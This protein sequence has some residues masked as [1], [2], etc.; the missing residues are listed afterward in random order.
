MARLSLNRLVKWFAVAGAIVAAAVVSAPSATA[1]A[2][3]PDAAPV[4]AARDAFRPDGDAPITSSKASAN[5]DIDVVKLAESISSIISKSR[6]R[7]AFVQ[8]TLD[9]IRF[10][11]M[12]DGR[13]VTQRST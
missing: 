13:Q 5:I 2:S 1:V 12:K 11:R 7:G 9:T 8:S 6:D 4:V 3:T 10:S